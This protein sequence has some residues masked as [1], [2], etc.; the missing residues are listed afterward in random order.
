MKLFYVSL[1]LFLG[2]F[3]SVAQNSLGPR[4]EFGLYLP[5][6]PIKIHRGDSTVIT[7]TILK[8]K[9]FAKAKTIVKVKSEL[10]KGVFIKTSPEIGIFDETTITIIVFEDAQVGDA[11]L[12]ITAE[13]RQIKKVLITT[14]EIL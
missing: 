7:L 5:N 2:S 3:S 4:D 12:N 9:G 8:S 6:T 14:F 10:P 13:M 1:I 11:T